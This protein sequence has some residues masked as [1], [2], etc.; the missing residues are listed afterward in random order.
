MG[1][2][3]VVDYQWL[4]KITIGNRYP[5]TIMSELQDRVRGAQIFT[6]IDL[7][8]SYQL[9]RVKKKDEWKTTFRCRYGLYEFMV[10]PFSLTNTSVT[11]KDMI[12]HIL[13]DLVDEGIVVC[14]SDLLIY[15]KPKE[16]LTYL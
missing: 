6:K 5:L 1:L 15:A 8:N 10:I 13:K 2:R 3:L 12:N 16:K 9:I 11:L 4:N 14:M 7:K